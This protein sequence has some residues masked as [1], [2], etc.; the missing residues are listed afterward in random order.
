[1]KELGANE[2]V[3]EGIVSKIKTLGD[4]AQR[5]GVDIQGL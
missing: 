3:I 5:A 1:L 4:E 2:S